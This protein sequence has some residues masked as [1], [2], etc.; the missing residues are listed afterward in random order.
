VKRAEIGSGVGA[1]R[2]TCPF[3]GKVPGPPCGSG[4]TLSGG[5]ERFKR[6]R[7]FG[8]DRK[9]RCGGVKGWTGQ[10]GS[11]AGLSGPGVDRMAFFWGRSDPLL[12]RASEPYRGDQ[13]SGVRGSR[14]VELFGSALAG[15]FAASAGTPRH[16]RESRRARD[17]NAKAFRL[18]GLR[19]GF[20]IDT[21]RPGNSL[22]WNHQVLS[23][24]TGIKKTPRRFLV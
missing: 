24:R 10:P 18:G 22:R 9:R 19:I 23:G 13:P 4:A 8:S 7:P 11:P 20:R 5:S 17:S 3:R 12:P 2:G 21:L 14:I 6:L 15:G 1:F 16:R